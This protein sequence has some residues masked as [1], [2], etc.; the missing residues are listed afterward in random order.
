MSCVPVKAG[1]SASTALAPLPGEGPVTEGEPA[2][3]ATSERPSFRRSSQA[4]SESSLALESACAPS[5]AARLES[6]RFARTPPAQTKPA[7][8]VDAHNPAIPAN[9]AGMRWNGLDMAT[10]LREP[11]RRCNRNT[12]SFP[13]LFRSPP[14]PHSSTASYSFCTTSESCRYCSSVQSFC[15][16]AAARTS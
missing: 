7:S 14:P 8:A 11:P 10:T 5:T 6:G 12:R 1:L 9:N 3:D 4:G 15:C 16:R 2:S 13:D